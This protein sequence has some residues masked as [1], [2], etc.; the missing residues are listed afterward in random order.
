MASP[1]L[2]LKEIVD[3]VQEITGVS[4]DIS[5]ICRLLAQHGLTR[6]KTAACCSPKDNGA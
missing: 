6:K 2:R 1:D 4:V 5:T 3:K